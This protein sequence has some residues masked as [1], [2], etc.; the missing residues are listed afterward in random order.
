MFVFKL[1][2]I[3]VCQINF[4]LIDNKPKYLR[5][6]IRKVSDCNNHL[7]N[8]SEPKIRPDLLKIIPCTNCMFK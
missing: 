1:F 5:P 8:N 3:F 2:M 4:R 6:S 7:I